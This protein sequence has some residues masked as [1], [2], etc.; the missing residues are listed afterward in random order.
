MMS[1]PITYV[2]HTHQD[3]FV[4]DR[5]DE[6]RWGTL[7]CTHHRIGAMG[8]GRVLPVSGRNEVSARTGVDSP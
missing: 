8:D 1:F 7:D 2:P 3:I 6:C 4:L 5:L